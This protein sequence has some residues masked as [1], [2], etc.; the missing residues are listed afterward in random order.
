MDFLK[1]VNKHRRKITQR[2][3]KGL[4]SSNSRRI[5]DPNNLPEIK[6]ILICR[7]NHRLGNLLLITPIVQE[8]RTTFPDCKIDL[9]VKGGL[10]PIVFKNYN[11]IDTYI[12]LPK[13]PFKQLFKYIKTWLLIR[14]KHYDI[15]LNVTSES[16]SGRLAT[17][18]SK[19]TFKIFGDE[20]DDLF[21]TNENYYHIA[22]NPVISFNQCI[23]NFGYKKN[24]EEIPCLDLKLGQSELKEGKE[25]MNE[26]VP[27]NKETIC[28]FTFAT[29]NKCFSESWWLSFYEKLK[30]K[31]N[32]YNI[33]EVLPVEN[34]S[35]IGFNAPSFYSKDIREIAAFIANTKVF[36][37]ADSGIMH[38]ASSSLT[39]TIGLFSVTPEKKYHPYQNNS[40]AFNTNN[41][42]TLDCLNIIDSILLNTE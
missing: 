31:Y 16:S 29:G 10:A 1:V 24:K 7:P 39:P 23:M 37:G 15:V 19:S 41:N 3:T 34:V 32:N 17:K 21:N 30:K 25:K 4:S 40:V 33:V 35:Q 36:I 42:T 2:I 26:L 22:K 8:V 11:N 27:D 9:F 12:E 38:L 20:N 13:K 14:K 5:Y 18:F 6:R 28:I